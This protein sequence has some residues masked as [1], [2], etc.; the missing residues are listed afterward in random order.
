MTISSS[1]SRAIYEQAKK[2]IPGGVSSTNRL[3]E[4]NL[5]FTRAEGAYIFDAE[6]RRYLDY[7]AGFDGCLEAGCLILNQQIGCVPSFMPVPVLDRD[8][9]DSRYD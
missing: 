6:G 9:L 1:K 7:H 5:V 8:R 3:V 4:P 2:Y